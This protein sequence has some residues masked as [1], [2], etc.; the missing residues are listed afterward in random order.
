MTS[1][2]PQPL[3]I[4]KLKGADKKNPKRYAQRKAAMMPKDGVG[5]PPEY[6]SEGAKQFWLET[7]ASTPDGVLTE[8]DR[9]PL[10]MLSVL[11]DEFRQ[12]GELM[13]G[14]R[15]RTMVT[16]ISRFGMT[17]GD[18]ARIPAPTEKQDQD[19]NPFDEFAA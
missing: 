10:E 19:V 15:M 6:M 9:L 2:F 12:K 17:P 8:L 11:T 1:P 7:V 16:L 18:R 3:A 13:T 4:A 5:E 14:V